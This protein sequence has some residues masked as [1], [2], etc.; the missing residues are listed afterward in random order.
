MADFQPVLLTNSGK[1]ILA[2]CLSGEQLIYKR[3][4]L[5]DG[6]INTYDEAEV[7]TSLINELYST[8]VYELS[9]VGD[10]QANLKYIFTN[11]GMT[12]DCYI[13]EIGV[14]VQD[15][16]NSDNEVLYAVAY[17]TTIPE[18][19]SASMPVL[20][21]RTI[22][23][24]IGNATNVTAVFGSI[25]DE[26]VDFTYHIENT[27]DAHGKNNPGGVA[28]L[29]SSGKIYEYQLPLSHS[30]N[31]ANGV[32]GLDDDKK[33]N[34]LQ[35]PV[36]TIDDKGIVELATVAESEIGTSTTRA[37]TPEGLKAAINNMPSV[38][39]PTASSSN[40]GIIEIATHDELMAGYDA[41]KAVSAEGLTYLLDNRPADSSVTG[42]GSW[43]NPVYLDEWT[44]IT[45]EGFRLCQYRKSNDG[46]NIQIT[47]FVH[48]KLSTS[49][50]CF[51]LPSGY[52]PTASTYDKAQCSFNSDSRSLVV[53]SDGNVGVV[54]FKQD[55]LYGLNA[56]IPIT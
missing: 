35:L 43:K 28:G 54:D 1:D 8:P 5:G 55:G 42:W 38:S 7:R 20:L 47:G 16:D 27:I 2:R 22:N 14:Y 9:F 13:R 19:Y 53:K 26:L 44:D 21:K 36:S 25:A 18:H 46:D 6:Q 41:F 24:Q 50:Y 11:S 48:A 32:A 39:I 33:I 37:V 3:V 34:P 12:E 23:M 15:L 31:A 56:I 30:V 29:D 49:L 45:T 51:N 40:K 52:R 17:A 10:G 4:A